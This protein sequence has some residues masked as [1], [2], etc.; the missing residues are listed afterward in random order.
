MFEFSSY[1]IHYKKSVFVL[2]VNGQSTFQVSPLNKYFVLGGEKSDIQFNCTINYG[3]ILE[4]S[5]NWLKEVP[6]SPDDDALTRNNF[7]SYSEKFEIEGEYN[8]LIRNIEISDAIYYVCENSIGGV[9]Q[10][11]AF[12]YLIVLGKFLKKMNYFDM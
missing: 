11:Q 3:S 4:T 2:E 10:I 5:T 12:A 6:G 8:L 9:G 1:K 7:S